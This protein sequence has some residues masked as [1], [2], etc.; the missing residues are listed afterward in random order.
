M[1]D[2]QALVLLN[3]IDGI[4]S[5]RCKKLVAAF[6]APE[7]IFK[8]GLNDILATGVLTARM[9]QHVVEAP[10]RIDVE[11]EILLCQR[12]KI[13][14]IT[15]LD[16][17]YPRL[18]KEI[19]DP[20]FVLY[21]KGDLIA[22]DENAVGIVGSRGASFYGLSCAKQFSMALARS[23]LTI[24]S[25]M[26]RGID[27]VSHRACLDE[28]G[29][30]I[31]VL[32]S[33]LKRVYPPENEQL[34][35][36][37]ACHGVVVS[38]FPLNTPPLACNFP[39]R[40][41]I[42]SGLSK[43][44]LVVEASKKSGALITARYALEQNRQVFALPGKVSSLTSFGTNE[45]IKQGARMVTDPKEILED[46]HCHFVLSETRDDCNSN[47]KTHQEKLEGL[48][49]QSLCILR[50]ID[51]DLKHID[52]ICSQAQMNMGDCLS[53]L[54]CLELKGIVKQH[55]GK[56]FSRVCCLVNDLH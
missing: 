9:A 18:L 14:I 22:C 16:E 33:G 47:G 38:Q 4:G 2:F 53:I 7:N 39:V 45:L 24:V 26:A 55:A 49:E 35:C 44:V 19:Y 34:F 43:G 23:G 54:T 41:R 20:P 15:I 32:G 46:L 11:A 27:T 51:D 31:A 8:A 40:N 52:T 12:S 13:K 6:G 50:L 1:T 28:N 48:D 10:K 30:T 37:I 29:R 56:M 42:I 36:D 3:M 21:V 5:I 17:E 25:G